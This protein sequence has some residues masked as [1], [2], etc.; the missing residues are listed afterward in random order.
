MIKILERIESNG[1]GLVG[2]IEDDEKIYLSEPTL[3]FRPI[4]YSED[5]PINRQQN[6]KYNDW[7]IRMIDGTNNSKEEKYVQLVDG[8][9]KDLNL[10]ELR[11]I[12]YNEYR[13]RK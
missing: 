13:R 2:F 11:V 7:V 10:G 3:K 4:K 8:R 12:P 5:N 6:E 9:F 1:E